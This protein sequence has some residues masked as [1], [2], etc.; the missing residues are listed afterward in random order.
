MG[1]SENLDVL[2]NLKNSTAIYDLGLSK[3]L[4]VLPNL[5]NFTTILCSG[6]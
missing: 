4:N 3:N 5:K 2:L 1:L 6:T